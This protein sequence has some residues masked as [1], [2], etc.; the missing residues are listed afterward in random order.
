MRQGAS[1]EL[2]RIPGVD[3][4]DHALSFFERADRGREVYLQA[5]VDGH[6]EDRVDE[7]HQ[8]EEHDVHQRHHLHARLAL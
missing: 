1:V 4:H 8:H 3:R 7:E 6:V 2:K 5:M